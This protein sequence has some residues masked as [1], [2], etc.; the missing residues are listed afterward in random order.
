M[1]FLRNVFGPSKDE[2][3]QQVADEMGGKF[4]DGGFLG[5]DVLRFQS[6]EWEIT[7]DTF[8]KN[9]GKSS[10][11]Y[12]RMRAPFLNKNNFRFKIY[13]EGFF[14]SIGKFF[15]MQDVE[16]K[17]LIFDNR[18][19]IKGNDENKVRLLLQDKKLRSLINIQSDILFEVKDDNGWFGHS[20]PDGVDEVYFERM[21]V[22]KNIDELKKLFE[23]FSLTLERLVEM[24]TAYKSNPQ[25][26]L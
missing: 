21:Y 8:T 12:T 7:L 19:I 25:I 24:D 3:W 1:G 4:T 6:G 15:G 20:F 13:H 9:H 26:R 5:K 2:I 18:F 22:M 11:T 23:L 16:I 10:T 17:D 14:S